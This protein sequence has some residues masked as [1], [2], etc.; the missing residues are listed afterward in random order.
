MLLESLSVRCHVFFHMRE[1]LSRLGTSMRVE[2]AYRCPCSRSGLGAEIVGVLW[3]RNQSGQLL[4]H[5]KLVLGSEKHMVRGEIILVQEI[6]SFFI[7]S[8]ISLAL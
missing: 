1:S 3:Q 2:V 7:R 6:S 4:I 5:V 8:L